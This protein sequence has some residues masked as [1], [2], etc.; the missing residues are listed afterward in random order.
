MTL[1]RRS[2]ILALVIGAASTP[3]SSRVAA[4]SQPAAASVRVTE[5]FRKEPNGDVLAR[6]DP[7]TALTVVGRRQDWMEV[8]LDGWVW[9]RSL[10][11][12][13][14]DGLDL[15]VS[16]DGGENLRRT[17]S[18]D[19]TGHLAEGTLLAEVE[20]T[21]GWIHVR[22]Q[23]WIWAASVTRPVP[24]PAASS[25]AQPS[26]P[27]PS[28]PPS[29]GR[30]SPSPQPPATRPAGVATTGAGGVAIL[31]APGGD[32]VARTSSGTELQVLSRQ[33]GW[34]RV[35]LEGWAWRPSLDSA[36]TP[37]DSVQVLT[38]ADLTREPK[39]FRGRLVSWQLQF[40]S[41]EHA[42]KVRT[43]FFEGEPFLLT[44]FG[45]PD[46]PFVYVAIPEA[47]VEDMRGLIPLERIKVTGRVRTGAS[48]LTGTPIIDL[49]SMERAGKAP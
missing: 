36:R 41:L 34:A 24:P 26:S 6:L 23:G 3:A 27:V 28:A 45:G 1:P 25:A 17:P 19:V 11:V 48:A 31:S 16:A 46:G 20:R 35:R 30:S 39:A 21:P 47:R 32:T 13:K 15:V 38:P 10:Q 29:S 37:A 8:V 43:D 33:G 12:A 49:V 4:Q 14:R 5:N 22:R 42:E 9:A 2:L 7:G 40:I 44:R 18:G